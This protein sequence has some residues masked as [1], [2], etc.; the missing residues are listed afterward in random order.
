M[1][2][3][4]GRTRAALLASA[5]PATATPSS[6][7][8]T[9][10]AGAALLAVPGRAACLVVRGRAFFRGASVASGLSE[11]STAPGEPLPPPPPLRGG[12]LLSSTVAPPPPLMPMLVSPCRDCPNASG[13]NS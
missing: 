8:V 10:P 5:A 7:K 6:S 3:C 11:A 2:W 12:A 4:S 13:S 9:K 1:E